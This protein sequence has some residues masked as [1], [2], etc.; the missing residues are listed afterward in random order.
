MTVFVGSWENKSL[1]V[2]LA[3]ILSCASIVVTAVYILR[4]S[5]K[6]IMGPIR[7]TFSTLSDAVWYE[8]M[9]AIFLLAGIFVMGIAPFLLQ[10]II[11]NEAATIV[12]QGAQVL[13]N[14]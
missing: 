6:V 2:R 11:G 9:A 4:A 7:E 5:G 10:Y 3:T 8:K 13:I 1:W 14:K 12:N